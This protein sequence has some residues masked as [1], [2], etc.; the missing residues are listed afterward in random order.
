LF[1]VVYPKIRISKEANSNH[2]AP[3]WKL[4][5]LKNRFHSSHLIST[6]P[7]LLTTRYYTPCKHIESKCL[8]G[9]T[10]VRLSTRMKEIIF[11]LSKSY[12]Y[13]MTRNHIIRTIENDQWREITRDS[14]VLHLTP[15]LDRLLIDKVRV[16]YDRTLARLRKLGL[17]EGGFPIELGRLSGYNGTLWRG[18]LYTLTDKGKKEAHKILAE[19]S[20][21]IRRYDEL[22]VNACVLLE[23]V[24]Q[25][26]RETG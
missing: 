5:E 21:T 14:Q 6:K 8:R 1:Q 26:V 9:A 20:K 25:R 12:D 22:L 7:Q 16:S 2:Q 3:V 23:E 19:A 13:S 18:Y 24:R 10:R 11:V 4:A 17:I 15:D